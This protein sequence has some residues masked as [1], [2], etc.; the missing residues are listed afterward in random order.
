MR[1]FLLFLLI[2]GVAIVIASIYGVAHDQVTY[3][4]SPEY[5]TKFKFIQ[6]NLADTVAAQHMTQP[7]SAV[8][9]T[10][11]MATWWMG[12]GIGLVLGLF[13]LAFRNGDMM[14]RSALTALWIVLGIAV[15]MAMV[16]YFYGHYVLAKK[17]VDWW[18]PP[19]LVDKTA[20]ITVGSI[21]NFSYAGGGIG[22][23]AGIVYL[24][25]KNSRLRR[26]VREAEYRELEEGAYGTTKEAGAETTGEGGAASAE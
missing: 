24:L 3:T 6:F 10:G 9:M 26:R 25:V 2:I 4:I 22:M 11:V 19:T 23:L 20:F 16:G 12:L 13:A 7:R 21:H 5:Y 17:G 14:F 1:K 15:L 18:L 8:V